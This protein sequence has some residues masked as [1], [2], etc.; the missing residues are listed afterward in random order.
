MRILFYQTAFLGDLLLST[1]FLKS[2]RRFYPQAQIDLVCRVGLGDFFQEF[3]LVNQVFSVNKKDKKTWH[4]L[5]TDLAAQAE[6]DLLFCP[7]PSF[8]SAWMCGKIAARKK[9]A[10]DAFLRSWFFT[11]LLPKP[12]DLPDALRQSFLLAA[13]QPEFGRRWVEFVSQYRGA[14]AQSL[15]DFSQERVP[16][17]EDFSLALQLPMARI[18]SLRAK[19]SLPASYVCIAP[20]SV[21]AT[22]QWRAEHY[23]SWAR[24]QKQPVVILG[25]P[26][27]EELCAGIAAQI[28]KAI[29]LCAQSSL[30]ELFAILKGAD[31]LVCNDSGT[32]HMASCAECPTISNFGPTTLDLGYRPWSNHSL[33]NQIE[34]ACRPCGK[35]GHQ[36]CPLGTH[37][38]MVKL[39]PSQLEAKQRLFG[40]SSP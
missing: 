9:Y 19:F 17:P 37:D 23:V 27:E 20:G 35:H 6:Y 14:K 32:M 7:H 4:R 3:G 34:L 29:N 21:W 2:L 26:G 31:L 1:L 39:L 5:A 33:V 22:K 12:M 28:P 11:H 8:R 40:S 13:E 25:G 18:E 38:C 15:A 36:R 30:I 10:F 24:Q 16:I